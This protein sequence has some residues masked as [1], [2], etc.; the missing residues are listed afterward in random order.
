[1][2]AN[3]IKILLWRYMWINLIIDHWTTSLFVVQDCKSCIP[4]ILMQVILL[5]CLENQNIE[6]TCA[7]LKDLFKNDHHQCKNQ[8]SKKCIIQLEYSSK[9]RIQRIKVQSY[10][11]HSDHL[12][13]KQDIVIISRYGIQSFW[14]NTWLETYISWSI[15]LLYNTLQC[16]IK[17]AL[18][19]KRKPFKNHGNKIEHPLSVSC[20]FV[21]ACFQFHT[22]TCIN[23]IL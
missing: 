10:T 13:H 6:K 3:F 16:N 7:I 15:F 1:M 2:K 20:N 17:A 12:I 14:K 22:C 18:V 21:E 19:Q 11:L 9:I 23:Y 8:R 4:D 5:E